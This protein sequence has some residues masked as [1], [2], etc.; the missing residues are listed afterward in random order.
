MGNIS[1]KER[2]RQYCERNNINIRLLCAA[3]DV[4]A[5]TAYAW[6]NGKLKFPYQRLAALE[7]AKREAGEWP[8]PG[9]TQEEKRKAACRK[10]CAEARKHVTDETYKKISKTLRKQRTSTRYFACQK[11][12][13]QVAAAEL[14][15]CGRKL[16][17]ATF[18][19]Q[20]RRRWADNRGRGYMF[21]GR[22][23]VYYF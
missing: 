22:K 13:K 11:H 15:S 21:E 4:S 16:S 2:L 3:A 7:R 19:Q 10:R 6:R 23:Q 8:V 18:Y 20:S 9:P 1:S 12:Y 5:W 17:F 14:E